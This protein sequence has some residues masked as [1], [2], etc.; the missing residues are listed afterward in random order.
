MWC[1]CICF[2]KVRKSKDYVFS[3]DIGW[4]VCI[5]NNICILYIFVLWNVFV[6]IEDLKYF[7]FYYWLCCFYFC[8]DLLFFYRYM[9]VDFEY[10]I[11]FKIYN[12]IEDWVV[13]FFRRMIFEFKILWMIIYV[14][15]I[16]FY[17]WFVDWL[18]KFKF[19]RMKKIFL[20]N[21]MVVMNLMKKNKKLCL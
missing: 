10:W 13:Y 14:I 15:K 7:I 4:E 8:E 1:I 21:N 9:I 17:Y 18:F 2:F 19:I 16:W 5:D 20:D 6:Y 3:Y 11:E 12:M